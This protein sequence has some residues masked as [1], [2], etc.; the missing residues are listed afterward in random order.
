MADYKEKQFF[1]TAQ[2]LFNA[3][4]TNIAASNFS[5]AGTMFDNTTDSVVPYA[6]MAVAVLTIEMVATPGAGTVME[7]WAV[8]QDVDGTTDETPVPATTSS[9]A[10]HCL[11]GFV[12]SASATP[13]TMQIVINLEGVQKF[14]PYLKNGSAVATD[15]ASSGYT[16]K[17]T[18][19][20]I[21]V[22]A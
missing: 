10:A 3:S 14:V 4:T 13:Q 5:A 12:L 17:I 2:T 18:P 22:T 8:M 1:G 20:A 7:L 6:P 9:N 11:G 21:G 19:F 15:V 16:L